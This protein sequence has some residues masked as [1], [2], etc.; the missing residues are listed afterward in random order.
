MKNI[1]TKKGDK[2]QSDLANG[3]RLSKANLRF[4]VIGDLDEL[5]SWL[6]VVVAKM[7]QPFRQQADFLQFLQNQ[8]FIVG[9]EIAQA[10]KV[11]V[12]RKLLVLIE[13][14]S[15]KLQQQMTDDWHSSFLLPGGVETAAWLDV[16][17]TICRRTER[18]LVKLKQRQ[19]VRPI[20]L[21]ILNRLSDYLYALRCYVN[22]ELNF[23]EQ[24]F[25]GK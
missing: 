4:E 18:H 22:H 17:R 24:E 6:G 12:D 5:N 21:K 13:Q 10:K 14:R 23:Q 3:R 15:E 9:A 11:E 16:A 7:D 20:L 19:T 25:K 8:L 2:G 1:S